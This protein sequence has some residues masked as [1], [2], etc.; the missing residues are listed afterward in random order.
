MG[1]AC[2]DG[3]DTRPTGTRG[4]ADP[5]TSLVYNTGR[6][7]QSLLTVSEC[8]D[9]SSARILS[10]RRHSATSE[11][12]ERL[13]TPVGPHRVMRA[14]SILILL[15]LLA[16]CGTTTPALST[17]YASSADNPN[18]PPVILVHGAFGG[19]L[20]AGATGEVWPGNVGDILFGDYRALALPMQGTPYATSQIALS[21]CGLTD[22]VVGRDFYGNI[23]TTLTGA[24]GYQFTEAGTPVH[25]T[26]RRYY[27][28]TYDWRQD[29]H[30]TASTLD[31]L[32]E[33]IRKDH[34]DEQLQVDI[35]AHSMGGLITRYW[36]RYG[37]VDVLNSNDF[38]VNNIGARK[39]RKVIL[40]GTPNL[41]STSALQQVLT[42]ADFGINTVAPEVLLTFPSAYQLLPHPIVDPVLGN[43]GSPLSRDIYD[44]DI[45]RALQ[46]GP[47]DPNVQ[48]RLQTAGWSSDHLSAL[49]SYSAH[50][51]ERARRFVWS[52]TV[53][54]PG[55]PH[56]L[57]VFGGNC[58]LTPARILI[59]DIGDVSFVR[60]WPD[61]IARPQ[62]G[63]DYQALMLEPGDGAVTK[64]SL[65]ARTAL[66]PSIPRH[67]YSD[68]PL[69]YPVMFCG[70][71]SDLP[72]N[73][74]F[75]DNLLHI[76]LQR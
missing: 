45:W 38:P 10:L 13:G 18:Q 68:F 15:S 57:I 35:V 70:D 31:A 65:L 64:A 4:I 53:K 48:A 59:E 1:T 2:P 74:T 34:D 8:S 24:G 55:A 28:F 56:K 29:N 44:V 3:L 60:L 72:G 50:H 6:S 12:T 54:N 20:C 26:Q 37:T 33:Q 67:R 49:A 69:D 40:V 30:L 9:E 42:G 36:L 46:W 32:V 58:V 75:Q 71:H 27:R 19:R 11:H 47:F 17:L 61:E 14:L 52:L 7:I 76:L 62:T 73:L 63:L 43:Q 25:D 41:G 23:E 51:L 22:T 5:S 16:A 39:A 21:P 66:D